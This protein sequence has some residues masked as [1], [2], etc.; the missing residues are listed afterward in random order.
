[1]FQTKTKDHKDPVGTDILALDI[2]RGRDHGLSKYIKYVEACNK[3]N[4][5]SWDDLRTFID[6]KVFTKIF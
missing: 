1:M 3:I 6:D 2:I 5:R 4:I